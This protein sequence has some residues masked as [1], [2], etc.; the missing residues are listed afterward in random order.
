[1]VFVK[2]VSPAPAAAESPLARRP[3]IYRHHSIVNHEVTAPPPGAADQQYLPSHFA[4]SCLAF[5]GGLGVPRFAVGTVRRRRKMQAAEPHSCCLVLL[6]RTRRLKRLLRTGVEGKIG[7]Y[8]ST[9]QCAKVK[10]LESQI[11][12]LNLW[13]VTRWAI[14]NIWLCVGISSDMRIRAKENASMRIS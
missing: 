11:D 6:Q 3:F 14:S 9:I 8:P 2:M 10:P 1:M 13:K 12:I 7:R 5:F 4:A